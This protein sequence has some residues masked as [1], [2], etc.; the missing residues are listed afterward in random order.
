MTISIWRYSHLALAVSSFILLA[1]ASITGIILAFQ[2]LSEKVLPYRTD[3][4]SETTLAR[5]LPVLRKQYPGISELTVDKNQFVQIRG[6]DAEGKKL[7]A[8]I[9]PQTGKIL[10]YPAPKSEFFEWVTALHRSLFIHETGRFLIGLTA[11]LLLLIT[12]SGTMLIIQRQRGLKRFFNRIIKDNFAQYYHVILGRLSLIPILIIALSGTYLSLARFGLIASPK[13]SAEVD[14][15]AIKSEPVKNPADFEIFKNIKL[16]EV[17]TVEFPFSEDPE[18]YYTLK[19]A[20]R[21]VTVNQ[22]TGD[23]LSEINYPTASM[24]TE[25]NLDLHTGRTN[26]VWAIILAVAS[27]NI[28][29]FIYSGFAMTFRRRANRIKNKYTAEESEFIILVGSENGSTFGFAN[30]IHKQLITNGK[31]AFVTELNNYRVFPKASNMIIMAATYGLGNPPTNAARF[32]T[33]LEK[34]KQPHPIRFSVVGFGSHGYPDFCKFA[35]EVDN[36]FAK[37]EWSIPT[38][39]IH[40]VNDK[41]PD[42]FGQWAA[43]WSQQAGIALE[44]ASDALTTRQEP[45]QDFTVIHKTEVTDAGES[46]LISFQANDLT[47]FTSGDLLAIYPANDHRERLYS[48]G[49]VGNNIQ[50][51]VKLHEGGLGSEYLYRLHSGSVISARIVGN[52]HFHFP[53]KVSSVIMISN[54]TG[55]APFLGMIDQQNPGANCRLYCGFRNEASFSLYKNTIDKNL[56]IN[57]LRSIHIAY[58][59]EGERQYVRDLLAADEAFVADTLANDGVIMLCG[60]LSM[61]NKVVALLDNI[62]QARLGKDISYYQSHSQVLMDCY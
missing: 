57:K 30:A 27:G 58:S 46:F 62:C 21:E 7:Q 52:E 32:A 54:G 31:S 53:E 59:R 56:K 29:F 60:S 12:V 38:L 40:T 51:S 18:D 44:I 19:L 3:N 55:I 49:K 26:A 42:E 45:L 6:S 39:E 20:N 48:I 14:F 61:Q 25:L 41:S 36:L 35:F 16:S 11:F 33:Q 8:Y 34:H 24:L 28:L 22:I 4:F 37:Q 2:P 9:D 50:L 17:Q 1:L 13:V 23:I 10:G 47:N 5:T 43:S 15:D